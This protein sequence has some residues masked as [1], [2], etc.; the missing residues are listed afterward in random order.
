MA[1][2]HRIVRAWLESPT[3]GIIELD[4]D[5]TGRAPP[6]FTLGKH[7][8][9]PS[10]LAPA[11]GLPAGR[12]DGYFFNN[13]D[14]VISFVL[15]L[16]HGCDV[17]PAQDKVYVA[18]DFNGWQEAV[19][20]EEWELKPADLEGE[21]VLLWSGDAARFLGWGQRFKFVTGEHQW[22]RPPDDAPNVVRDDHGNVNRVL[23]PTRTGWHL[24]RFIVREPLSLA[25]PWRVGWADGSGPTV[26]VVPGSFFYELKTDLPLGA[27]IR[28]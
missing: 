20:K 28:G 10:A 11:P 19:G 3:S 22:L 13:L 25:E 7:C 9:M 24:W 16:E 1:E 21:R 2:P 4:R 14:G 23:D 5:W 15:P 17:D 26:P 8:P 18:G 27:L 12:A 6:R